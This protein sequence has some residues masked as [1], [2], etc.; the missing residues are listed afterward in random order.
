MS[1]LDA[2]AGEGIA[3][4]YVVLQKQ[5]P[6]RTAFPGLL[7]NSARSAPL[8]GHS[9]RESRFHAKQT[10]LASVSPVKPHKCYLGIDQS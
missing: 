7:R 9:F 1:E 8:G 2:L 5:Q 3:G 4:N 10:G 6:S